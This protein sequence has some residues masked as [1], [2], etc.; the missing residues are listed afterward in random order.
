MC[1]NEDSNSVMNLQTNRLTRDLVDTLAAEQPVGACLLFGDE[2]VDYF[3][4]INIFRSSNTSVDHL[5]N[6]QWCT[7]D[8]VQ[9]YLPVKPGVT[10]FSFKCLIDDCSK[11][12]HLWT[13]PA[14]LRQH[15]VHWQ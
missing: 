13:A 10:K 15:L 14:Y 5:R 8:E 12:D 6:V 11:S 9:A 4:T 1:A 3:A 7:I 2:Y